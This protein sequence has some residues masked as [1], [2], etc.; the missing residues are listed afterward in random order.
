MSPAA[1]P[2]CATVSTKQAETFNYPFL[3][4][5]LDTVL[6]ASQYINIY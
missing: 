2:L 1:S 6:F 3:D 4:M 5:Q